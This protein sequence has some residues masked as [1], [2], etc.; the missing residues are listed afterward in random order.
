MDPALCLAGLQYTQRQKVSHSPPHWPVFC[1]NDNV[2]LWF[3]SWGKEQLLHWICAPCF[4]HS[5]SLRNV[6]FGSQ[7]AT[8]EETTWRDHTNLWMI[9]PR[10]YESINTNCIW[11]C[12]IIHLR[13]ESSVRQLKSQTRADSSLRCFYI[14]APDWSNGRNEMFIKRCCNY[15]RIIR[16]SLYFLSPCSLPLMF[17]VWCHFYFQGR[18][19]HKLMRFYGYYELFNHFREKFIK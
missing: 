18:W 10:K 13:E 12:V 1:H 14:F 16:V 8:I 15:C 6:M 17:R 5:F 9:F 4:N 19:Y 2:T 7:I 11:D 3:A